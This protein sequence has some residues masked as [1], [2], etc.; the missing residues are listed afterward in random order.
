MTRT[1]TDHL[2]VIVVLKLDNMS[3]NIHRFYREELSF[4]IIPTV[5]DQFP[6]LEDLLLKKLAR[7]DGVLEKADHA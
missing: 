3:G 2:T 4:D 5:K 7:L 1:N 6:V